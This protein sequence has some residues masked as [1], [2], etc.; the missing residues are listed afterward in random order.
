MSFNMIKD[1]ISDL[2][3]NGLRFD[4]LVLFWLGE[5]LL[6]HQFMEIYAHIL[7]KNNEKNIFEKIEVHTNGVLLSEEIANNL[8]NY[9]DMPQ[10]WHFS[11][12]AI[13]KDTYKKI[14]GYDLMEKVYSNIEHVLKRKKETRALFPRLVFQFIIEKDNFREAEEFKNHWIKKLNEH[15]LKKGV[16]GFHV[17]WDNKNYVFF[18]QLDNLNPD[19]QGESDKIYFKTLKKLGLLK[20]DRED[21][22]KKQKNSYSVCSGFF[23]SPAINWDGRV[24]VCTRDNKLKLCVGDLNENTFSEIW[25]YNKGLDDIRKKIIKGDYS[26]ASLCKDCIIPRSSNYTGI[27]K[28]EIKEYLKLSE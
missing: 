15:N 14:K 24:T 19:L 1:F 3:E 25:W 10:I 7:R 26:S 2:D 12:D 18:R 9:P 5:P 11:L 13:N 8:F 6:H 23:K 20:K 21:K 17:P 16:C 28:D 22:K 27:N 4:T